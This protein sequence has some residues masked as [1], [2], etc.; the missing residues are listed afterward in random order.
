[1]AM[2]EEKLFKRSA[3]GK[4]IRKRFSDITNCDPRHKSQPLFDQVLPIACS[5]LSSVDKEHIDHLLKENAGLMKLITEKNKVIEMNGVELQKMRI[6]LQKMQSQN[7]SLAQSNNHMMAELNLGKK[8][9]KELEHQ[10]ACKD[11]LLKAMSSELQVKREMHDRKCE[12]KDDENALT[13][14]QNASRRIRPGRSRSISQLT[15]VEAS[16]KELV[17]N[18]R[19]RVRRQS[20]RFMSQ[21]HE[22]DE[23]LFEIKDL[24][25]IVEDCGTTSKVSVEQNDKCGSKMQPEPQYSQRMSFGRPSRRAAE[26]VQSYK[27][28]PL[29]I[30]MRRPE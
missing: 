21:E 30:K 17:E 4:S 27:E 11:A 19:P 14:Q 24:I 8:K 23:N 16:E 10:L 29:N 12:S 13:S 20:A 2:R 6:V 18:K 9:L 7:W 22:P 26:K 1:M 3:F 5:V 15:T 28:V 25:K